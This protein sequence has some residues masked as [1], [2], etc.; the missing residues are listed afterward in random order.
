VQQTD[1]VALV[2]TEIA[3]HYAQHGMLAVLPIAL[4]CDMD[5][6]GIITR[7]DTPLP[8]A[9]E[10]FLALLREQAAALYGRA[11]AGAGSAL[12]GSAAP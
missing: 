12:S 11:P 2:P 10:S 6:F 9:V 1:L 5:A 7:R 3:L 4:A 8:P